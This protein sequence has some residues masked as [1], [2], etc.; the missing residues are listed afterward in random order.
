V[1]V[2]FIVVRATLFSSDATRFC[3]HKGDSAYWRN[4][5]QASKLW[6]LEDGTLRFERYRVGDHLAAAAEQTAR[7]AAQ[8]RPADAERHLLCSAH[9][10]ALA[11][12][13]LA[14][15][16]RLLNHSRSPARGGRK[17][18]GADH[19][20]GRS[21]GGLRTKIHTVVDTHGLPLKILLPPAKA[22]T[23]RSLPPCSR[24]SGQPST[25]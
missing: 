1:T 24:A 7:C 23:R 17:K 5:I 8:G 10:F 18:E 3:T 14:S 9:R 21:R 19:A 25:P 11:G 4:V 22:P 15:P 12:P 2:I 6:E 16:D 20:I 13:G